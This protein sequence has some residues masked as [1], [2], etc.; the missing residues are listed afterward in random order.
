M[1]KKNSGVSLKPIST[2]IGRAV[3]KLKG[4]R[5]K[6]SRADK[7]ILSLK[8]HKLE[9]LNESLYVLCKYGRKVM[10]ALPVVKKLPRRPVRS[11]R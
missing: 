3:K 6:A 1:A 11:Q 5:S 8:M 4:M 10:D 2:E 7:K 9:K